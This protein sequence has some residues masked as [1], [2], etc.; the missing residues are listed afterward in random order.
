MALR[1]HQSLSQQ[2]NNLL[3]VRYFHF[4]IVSLFNRQIRKMKFAAL[5]AIVS[6]AAIQFQKGKTTEAGTREANEQEVKMESWV[7][8]HRWDR[9]F[10]KFCKMLQSRLG[11]YWS[12]VSRSSWHEYGSSDPF[13]QWRTVSTNLPIYTFYYSYEVA[14]SQTSKWVS[15]PANPQT[16]CGSKRLLPLSVALWWTIQKIEQNCPDVLFLLTSKN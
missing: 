10:F 2:I 12:I 13:P 3:L 1:S 11:Q 4:W 16:K 15:F 7:R 8:P 6:G 5:I 14:Q 9:L